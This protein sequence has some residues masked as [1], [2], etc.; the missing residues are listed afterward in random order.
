M[1]EDV[2][3]HPLLRLLDTPD[4]S[5]LLLEQVA[6][7]AHQRHTAPALGLTLTR[8]QVQDALAQIDVFPR[9]A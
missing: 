2:R 7:L 8:M 3:D 6:Q 9:A 4:I 5:P 1:D